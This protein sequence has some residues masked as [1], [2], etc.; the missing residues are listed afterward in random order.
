M[1]QFLPLLTSSEPTLGVPSPQW[2]E[3]P[4]VKWG[5]LYKALYSVDI[6]TKLFWPNFQIH[7]SVLAGNNMEA[8]AGKML[9]FLSA[10]ERGSTM[11]ALSTRA[12]PCLLT[13]RISYFL[14]NLE[15]GVP[16]RHFGQAI[17]WFLF[18]HAFQQRASSKAHVT[19]I[20]GPQNPL[21][22]L[23]SSAFL[24]HLRGWCARNPH[25]W[26]QSHSKPFQPVFNLDKD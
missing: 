1:S 9:C 19:L 4:S 24:C 20:Q 7:C 12:L 18:I 21:K 10:R 13:G 26:D 5:Q 15:Q 25:S 8:S 17:E 11:L 3:Y 23:S 6:Y 14:I 22:E 16:F 2:R